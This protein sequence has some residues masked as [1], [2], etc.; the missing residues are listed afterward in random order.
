MNEKFYNLSKEKQDRMI[1]GA[2]KVFAMN[3]YDKASTDTIIQEAGISKGL[4]FHYFGSKKNLYLYVTEY[5][6]RFLTMELRSRVLD[7]SKNLFERVKLV[8]EAKIRMLQDYPY[9]DLFLISNSAEVSPEVVACAKEWARE[10]DNVYSE[11]IEEKSDEDLI[12]GNLTLK[13]ARE[14]VNLCM[15]GYKIRMYKMCVEPKKVLEGFL[16]YLDIL[17]NNFTK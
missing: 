6:A 17:K 14:I 3:G 5:C 9:L 4:L 11:M 12:R 2:I 15:E 16:P 1:N 8:E 7:E 13:E 10:V